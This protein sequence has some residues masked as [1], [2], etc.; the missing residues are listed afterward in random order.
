MC[1]CGM[2]AAEYQTL[3]KPMRSAV[4]SFFDDQEAWLVGVLEQGLEEGTLRFSGPTSEAAQMI[5]GGLEG[6]MLVTRPYGDP[7]RFRAAAD[8]LLASFATDAPV[9][10]V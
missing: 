1:L 10:A 2:L 4:V 6:A 7:A 3:P 5:V 8:H 9:T